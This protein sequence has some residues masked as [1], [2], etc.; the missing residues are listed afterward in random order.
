MNF[1]QLIAAARKAITEGK[2]D[3]AKTYTDQA[4]ALKELDSLVP[5]AVE[6]SP[7]FVAMKAKLQ[8]YDAK[9]ARLEAE[10]PHNKAGHLTVTE[11]ETD[12]KAK[13]PFKSLGDQLKAVAHAYLYPQGMDERLKAQKAVLGANEG[14]GS[15]GGFLVQQD[16]SAEL[17]KIAHETGIIANRCR[18]LPVGPNANGI[19]MNAID[20]TS[21]ATGSRFGGVRGYWLAEGGVLTGSQPKFRQIELNLKKLGALMYATEEL[22]SDTM[23]LGAVMQMGASEELAFMLD[24]SLINGTGAGMPVGVLNAPV[25][26]S[27]AKESGQAAASLVFANIQKMWARLHARSRANAVWFINQDVEPALNS[28]EFPVGTGGVPVYL[29][30]GGLSAAPY[31]TLLGRPIVPTEFNATLGTVG[32]ILLADFSQYLIAEKG[33]I[34][35]ESSIHVQFLTDQTAFRWIYRVDGQPMWN[36]PLTPFKGTNTL[37]PF[38]ALATRA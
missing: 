16:F 24:D 2:L 12:K 3:L 27:I 30:P 25:L 26:V 34:R 18:R 28:M 35:A 37:S 15:D 21:R 14:Q 22:L 17:F 20:E 33:G 1:E 31:A 4:K 23:A 32:D 8:D 11:D 19:K 38:V 10:P 6:D 13:M 9:W 29:P 36:A 5:V 7:E